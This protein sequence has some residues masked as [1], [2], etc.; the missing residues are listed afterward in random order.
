[1]YRN[2]LIF[3]LVLLRF[4]LI[5]VSSNTDVL[6]FAGGNGSHERPYLIKTAGQLIDMARK[7]ND[8]NA[9]YGG[10]CYRL[11]NDINLVFST[12]DDYQPIGNSESAT[13]TGCFEGMGKTIRL[14]IGANGALY[15]ARKYLGLFGEIDGACN[16]NRV[17]VDAHIFASYTVGDI[18]IKDSIY[19]GGLAANVIDGKIKKNEIASAIVI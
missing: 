16:I 17:K 2:I 4:P 5:N 15:N 6:D 3:I 13:F 7:V 11:V 18:T 12:E 9:K 10:R 8:D 19:C 1:M 14:D